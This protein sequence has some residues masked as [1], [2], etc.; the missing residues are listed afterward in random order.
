MTQEEFDDLIKEIRE[1]DPDQLSSE[2]LVREDPLKEE[3]LVKFERKAGFQ[4]PEE[5][6]YFLRR[7]GS[8]EILA[9]PALRKDGRRI[10]I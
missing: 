4:F 1:E 2:Y 5:Y 7:Y 3:A 8:G 6:R 10:S 9:V